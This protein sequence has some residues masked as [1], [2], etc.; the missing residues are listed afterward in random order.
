M[1]W[2]WDKDQNW[3]QNEKFDRAKGLFGYH[4]AVAT[5]DKKQP[6]NYL[7]NYALYFTSN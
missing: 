5:R 7:F 4:L 1:F 2:Y 6:I 3:T